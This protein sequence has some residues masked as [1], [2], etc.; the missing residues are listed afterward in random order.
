MGAYLNTPVCEKEQEEDGNERITYASTSM[1]GWRTN[2]EV[3]IFCF[4]SFLFVWFRTRIT[5][6]LIFTAN[7]LYLPYMMDTEVLLYNCFF[8][9]RFCIF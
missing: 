9:I 6:F 4:Y 2:Q 8:C 7:A 3:S 1:Q 5:A